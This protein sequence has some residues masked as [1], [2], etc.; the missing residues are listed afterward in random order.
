MLDTIK[1]AWVLAHMP[2]AGVLISLGWVARYHEFSGK[3]KAWSYKER[4]GSRYPRLGLF[5]ANNGIL[6]VTAR[7]SLPAF[8]NGSNAQL[9]TQRETSQGLVDLSRYVT[10]KLDKS[11]VI[12][13][14]LVWE[15]HFTKDI[16]VGEENMAWVIDNLSSMSIAGFEKG[17][18][19]QRTLYYHSKGRGKE[20]R[21]PRLLCIYSKKADCIAKKFS[22]EDIQR[23]DGN[24]R[25][26]F[27]FRTPAAVARL[28]RNHLLAEEWGIAVLSGHVSQAVLRPI[29]SQMRPLLNEARDRHPIATLKE[30]YGVRRSATLIAFLAHLHFYGSDFYKIETVGYSR[31]VYY[32]CLKRCREAGVYRLF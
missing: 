17:R 24:L 8:V 16:F 31:S 27:R 18:Y 11:L 12:E 26:E 23:A 4:K 25:V 15:A 32:D 14:A 2:P 6:Y 28:I 3:L 5:R 20:D 13:N 21:K 10:E 1:L 19:S 29:E 7:I 22:L 30:K 9:L